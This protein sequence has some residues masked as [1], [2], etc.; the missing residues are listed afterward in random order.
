MLKCGPAQYRTTRHYGR[1]AIV[2]KSFTHRAD[3]P[4]PFATSPF[5]HL[6]QV[7][8]LFHGPRPGWGRAIAYQCAQGSSSSSSS[9]SNSNSNSKVTVNPG[10]QNT[11]KISQKNKKKQ[12][13][14]TPLSSYTK[15]TN[16][17]V[18]FLHPRHPL[19]RQQIQQAKT[20]KNRQ[21]SMRE[22]A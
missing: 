16:L 19:A 2:H 4:L 5:C 15:M 18:F 8:T 22:R 9:N 1:W 3:C 11:N 17:S 7:G 13:T 14:K 6:L 20:R 21:F 12:P 10:R